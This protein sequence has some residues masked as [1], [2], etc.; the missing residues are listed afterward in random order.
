MNEVDVG[1]DRATPAQV[2]ISDPPFYEDGSM[3]G[4]DAYG[5][6]MHITTDLLQFKS[7]NFNYFLTYNMESPRES[8]CYFTPVE[9]PP[10]SRCQRR[11]LTGSLTGSIATTAWAWYRR[12]LM[13]PKR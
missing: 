10:C 7:D 5:P 9:W 1:S 11:L 8:Q 13:K 2:A 4:M 3:R 12:N 6:K